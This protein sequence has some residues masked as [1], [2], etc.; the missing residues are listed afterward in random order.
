[1]I[2]PVGRGIADNDGGIVRGPPP[3]IEDTISECLGISLVEFVE[4]F[5]IESL[6]DTITVQQQDPVVARQWNLLL[7]WTRQ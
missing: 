2:Q 7:A 1:M 4:G 5:E 6:A 3:A